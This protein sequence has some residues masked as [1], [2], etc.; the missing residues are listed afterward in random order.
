M[1]CPPCGASLGAGVSGRKRQGSRPDRRAGFSTASRG[2]RQRRPRGRQ[3]MRQA[4]IERQTAETEI[5]VEIILDGTGR[6]E[7]ATGVGFFD[8]ML[9]QLARHSLIDM[10]VSATGDLHVDDHHTVEDT[11]IAL[12]QAL[13]MAL[14]DKR[15]IRRYGA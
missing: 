13:S 11:G 7:M 2:C 6:Y 4:R 8:H 12:G 5:A 3:A 1:T 9:D 14:G 15:G 10:T